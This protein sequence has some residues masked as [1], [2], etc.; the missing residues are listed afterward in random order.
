[1]KY[2]CSE[3]EKAPTT[4]Q[5]HYQG[6]V[7]LKR[8]QRLSYVKDIHMFAHW[9]VAHGSADQNRKYCSKENN[10]SFKEYGSYAGSGQGTRTDL[11][12]VS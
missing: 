12:G 5:L 9:E 2:K 1:M 6:Y 8:H 10:G 7:V 3:Q 4:G 11:E